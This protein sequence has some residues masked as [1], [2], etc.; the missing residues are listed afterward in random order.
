MTIKS[1]REQKMAG[2]SYTIIGGEVK[3]RTPHTIPWTLLVL[4]RGRSVYQASQ[5]GF[6]EIISIES[7]GRRK[8]DL[9]ET[10]A[11]GVKFL[12][13]ETAVNVGEQINI[14]ISAASYPFVAVIWN[15]MQLKTL[16]SPQFIREIEE[17][18]SVCS[19]PMLYSHRGDLI[20]S[21]PTPAHGRR[22]IKTIPMTAIETGTA[23]L[24]PFDYVGI[25]NRKL[26][27]LAGG[28]DPEINSS[29]WQ[30]M[31]FGF[32]S[33]LWGERIQL[34]SSFRIYYTCDFKQDDATIDKDYR[35]FYLRNLAVRV[36][37]NLAYLPKSGI[38]SYIFRSGEG[39][40]VAVTEYKETSEWI[41]SNRTR[42]IQCGRTLVE[43]WNE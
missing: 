33:W 31:D 39:P 42:F 29:Y 34:N 18:K 14:G 21:I 8:R 27:Q 25:Y 30:K 28:Y 12:I 35:R 11:P 15:D 40:M 5:A 17:G 19:V 37:D 36:R 7:S 3:N 16:F 22:T 26:F 32:R 6:A 1:N 13:T 41:D 20:P 23:A 2:T 43:S 38:F 10:S 9:R 24:Y 4:N